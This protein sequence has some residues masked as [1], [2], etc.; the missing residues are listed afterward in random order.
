MCKPKRPVLHTEPTEEVTLM[1]PFSEKEYRKR[2]AALNKG[3]AARKNYRPIS[4]L[5][6]TYKLYERLIL[7]R[8]AP[9][10]MGHLI[11]AHE[12]MLLNFTQHL[13]DR[14]HW[15]NHRR[16]FYRSVFSLRYIEPYNSHPEAVQYNTRQYTM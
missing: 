10:A 6:H 15:F 7:N 4:L 3:K 12:V 14:Y 9:I 1:Y 11:K 13:E 2:I 8:I 16:R 5:W